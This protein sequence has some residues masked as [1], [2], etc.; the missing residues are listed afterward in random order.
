MQLV[1]LDLINEIVEKELNAVIENK[2]TDNN[3]QSYNT[4]ILKNLK[5]TG[6]SFLLI[7]KVYSDILNNLDEGIYVTYDY[8]HNAIED[9]IK[10]QIKTKLS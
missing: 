3:K 1:S 7:N 8:V 5:D 2:T 9:C 4:T 6:S 10:E